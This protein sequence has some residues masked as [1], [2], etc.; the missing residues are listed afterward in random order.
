MNALELKIPNYVERFLEHCG[1]MHWKVYKDQDLVQTE[2]GF[3]KFIRVENPESHSLRQSLKNQTILIK[4]G[5]CYRQVRSNFMALISYDQVSSALLKFSEENPQFVNSVAIFGLGETIKHSSVIFKN[6]TKSEVFREFE[7]FLV[8]T[9]QVK[10]QALNL[11]ESNENQFAARGPQYVNQKQTLVEAFQ[12]G[13]PFIL[14]YED[15][16]NLRK[17]ALSNLFHEN[18]QTDVSPKYTCWSCIATFPARI[19]PLIT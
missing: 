10:L 2:N 19:R 12:P 3:H 13:S 15:S 16:A 17:E 1:K 7:R 11:S 8:K 14:N 18:H 9:Y 5:A 6:Q 4:D